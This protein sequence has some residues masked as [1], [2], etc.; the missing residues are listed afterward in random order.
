VG[1][2]TITPT[3]APTATPTDYTREGFDQLYQDTLDNLQTTVQFTEK[4]L[5]YV[6]AM[7]LYREK[8]EK[9]VLDEL[10]VQPA[11]EEVWARHILVPD[12]AQ[13]QDILDRVNQGEDWNQ[14]AAEYSTDTTNKDSGGNLGWFGRGAMVSEFENAAFSLQAGEVVSKPVQTSFGWHV[15]QVV[16]HEERPLDES[17]YTQLRSDKFTEW[18]QGLREESEIQINDIWRDSVPEEPTLPVEITDFITAAQQQVA[19]P[20]AEPVL[21]PTAGSQ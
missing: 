6:V 8:I 4:D 3:A 21:T 9:A 1:T 5:R 12:E 16:G 7:Q 2:P 10:G 18:L 11:E 13:A 17:A 14:L 20:T 19:Q 15:I